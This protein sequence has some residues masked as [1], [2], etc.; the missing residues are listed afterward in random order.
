MFRKSSAFMSV[1][2]RS[3]HEMINWTRILEADAVRYV[4]YA[5]FFPFAAETGVK[6]L[7]GAS[8]SFCMHAHI[9]T[10]SSL[11]L[12]MEQYAIDSPYNKPVQYTVACVHN[13]HMCIAVFAH[14]SGSAYEFEYLLI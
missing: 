3:A 4:M 14:H 9:H 13:A 11:D 1:S 2:N 6:L 8:A 10:R 5:T 12:M 7:I